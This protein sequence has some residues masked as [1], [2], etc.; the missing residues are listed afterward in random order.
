MYAPAPTTTSRDS[1]SRSPAMRYSAIA[2]SR[3]ARAAVAG[4]ARLLQRSD[5]PVRRRKLAEE[6]EAPASLVVRERLVRGVESEVAGVR[7][8]DGLRHDPVA[9]RVDRR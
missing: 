8:V 6:L 4:E 9:D 3:R 5:H 7:A 1:P 2:R